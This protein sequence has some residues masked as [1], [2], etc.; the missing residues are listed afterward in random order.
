MADEAYTLPQRRYGL[1][2]VEGKARVIRFDPNA[3]ITASTEVAPQPRVLLLAL[4]RIGYNL[5]QVGKI[6][7]QINEK[8][9]GNFMY[10][11]P[12]MQI[13][14]VTEIESDDLYLPVGFGVEAKL[15]TDAEKYGYALVEIEE[16]NPATLG[17]ND[18]RSENKY[19]KDRKYRI[20]QYGEPKAEVRL[21]AITTNEY[22]AR[23][24]F[25]NIQETLLTSK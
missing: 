15:K 24:R 20:L 7:Q 13:A 19:R 25:L 10:V 12:A 1:E 21:R 4:D 9:L 8:D 14:I 11:N 18:G 17:T 3:P 6:E 22:M 5:E 2:I 16:E 23:P